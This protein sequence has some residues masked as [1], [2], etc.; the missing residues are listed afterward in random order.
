MNKFHS[1]VDGV[2]EKILKKTSVYSLAIKKKIII[3][4]LVIFFLV[5]SKTFF[6]FTKFFNKVPTSWRKK[7]K[8]LWEWEEEKIKNCKSFL[9][10]SGSS[11]A[12]A[13]DSCEQQNTTDSTFAIGFFRMPISFFFNISEPS[14][15]AVNRTERK[16][17]LYIH[18][19]Y[20]G[21]LHNNSSFTFQHFLLLYFCC[22][23]CDDDVNR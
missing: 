12:N 21:K 8:T 23:A 15:T 3:Y 7:E 20:N 5:F 9:F 2:F 17:K 19:Q 18:K 11:G 6:S 1:D 10:P 4:F 16:K 13:S 14:R 22:A